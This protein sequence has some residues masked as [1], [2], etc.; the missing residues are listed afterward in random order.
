MAEGQKNNQFFFETALRAFAT[1]LALNKRSFV[2]CIKPME[3][4]TSSQIT[5]GA[6]RSDCATESI[7]AG[8]FP[9]KA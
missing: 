9:S 3:K 4:M 7:K 6:A 5:M 2:S 8:D 1:T